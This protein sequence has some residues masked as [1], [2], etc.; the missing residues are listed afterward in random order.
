MVLEVIELVQIKGIIK[1]KTLASYWKRAVE[2]L[3]NPS[4]PGLFRYFL[5]ETQFICYKFILSLMN[6]LRSTDAT[7]GLS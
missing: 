7:A 5:Q 4:M 3:W 2:N 6:C 1:K